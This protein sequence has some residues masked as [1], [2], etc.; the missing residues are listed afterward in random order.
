[1]NHPAASGRFVGF[2][3]I[4][5]WAVSVAHAGYDYPARPYLEQNLT[6]AAERF[7]DDLPLQR[8]WAAANAVWEFTQEHFSPDHAQAWLAPWWQGGQWRKLCDGEGLRNAKSRHWGIT[9]PYRSC[10]EGEGPYISINHDRIYSGQRP[11]PWLHGRYYYVIA[12]EMA[13]A[14][15]HYYG[16]PKWAD[17]HW[18]DGVARTFGAAVSSHS[19]YC[20]CDSVHSNFEPQTALETQIMPPR[21][22]ISD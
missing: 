20:R 3:V 5:A 1:M 17:D 22:P 13:H 8:C 6:L 21:A 2:L 10:P 4:L 12:H 7:P 14:I 15:G 11:E 18:A 19:P 9:C 16:H